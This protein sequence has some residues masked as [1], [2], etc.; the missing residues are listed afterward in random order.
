MRAAHWAADTALFGLIIKWP[1]PVFCR[2]SVFTCRWIRIHWAGGVSILIYG[3]APKQAGYK[4]LWR[5]M[6]QYKC[7][8]INPSGATRLT[9]FTFWQTMTFTMLTDL[10]QISNTWNHIF[11]IHKNWY[12]FAEF[13]VSQ[14]RIL[15][16]FV[17]HSSPFLDDTFIFSFNYCHVFQSF[18]SSKPKHK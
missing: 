7:A 6:F 9:S 4:I 3:P 1:R 5:V 2:K 10:C 16:D 14:S 12:I 17:G 13:W 8:M 15:D 11:K 18:L